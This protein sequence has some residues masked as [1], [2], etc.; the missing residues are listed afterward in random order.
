[1][2]EIDKII[3]AFLKGKNDAGGTI[4]SLEAEAKRL[5]LQIELLK[6]NT[7]VAYNAGLEW[8]ASWITGAQMD[9]NSEEVR[10]YAR[11]MAMSIRAAKRGLIP[12]KCHVCN[13]QKGFRVGVYWEVCEVCNGMGVR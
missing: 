7:D 9:G 3:Q 11:N 4:A 13:G 2:S 10:D 8:A 12:E 6:K 5:T 1:M